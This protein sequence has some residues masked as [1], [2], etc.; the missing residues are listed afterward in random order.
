M[1][2]AIGP[3]EVIQIEYCNWLSR[4]FVPAGIYSI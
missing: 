4:L 3:F 2:I 1:H